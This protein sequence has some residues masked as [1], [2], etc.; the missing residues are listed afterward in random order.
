MILSIAIEIYHTS[1]CQIM[2]KILMQRHGHEIVGLPVHDSV[3]VEKQH[4]DLLYQLMMEEY[5]QL[6]EFAPVLK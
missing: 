3:I 6:M 4:H 5:E 1:Y 2:E